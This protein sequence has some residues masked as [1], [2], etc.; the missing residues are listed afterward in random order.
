MIVEHP[1]Y[2]QLTGQLH[3]SSRYD[4]RQFMQRL[5][6]SSAAPLSDL[7]GGVHL[8]TLLCNDEA[9]F[10]RVKNALAGKGYLYSEESC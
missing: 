9:A 4:V 2:G 3:L 6:N 10:I 8:H 7:T 5:G 1:V